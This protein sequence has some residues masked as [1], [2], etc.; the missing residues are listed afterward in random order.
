MLNERNQALKKTYF[1]RLILS[2]KMFKI[3]KS[4]R[5]IPE[6][7]LPEVEVWGTVCVRGGE[8]GVTTLE[9]GVAFEMRKIS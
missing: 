6:Y 8:Q 7:L 9:Y 2:Y 5:E 3:D 4:I 1:A